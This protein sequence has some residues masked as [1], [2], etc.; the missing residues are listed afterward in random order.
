MMID[1]TTPTGTS[2]DTTDALVREIED[3]YLPKDARRDYDATW[4]HK[5]DYSDALAKA[6]RPKA[7][8]KAR[9]R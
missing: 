2:L 4:G 3:R 6:A 1:I 8:A 7:K 9:A 5:A